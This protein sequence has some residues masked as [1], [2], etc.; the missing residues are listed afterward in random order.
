VSESVRRFPMF[1]WAED[2]SGRQS[3]DPGLLWSV[4]AVSIEA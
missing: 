2:W 1:L 3:V 4:E